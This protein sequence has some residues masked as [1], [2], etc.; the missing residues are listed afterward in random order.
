MVKLN[1]A[2]SEA[3]VSFV[4]S[5]FEQLRDIFHSTQPLRKYIERMHFTVVKQA[6]VSSPHL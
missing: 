4:A 3:P 1:K 6:S 5:V 2:L